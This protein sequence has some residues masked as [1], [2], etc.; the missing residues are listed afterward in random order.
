MLNPLV[1]ICYGYTATS[2]YKKSI[3]TAFTDIKRKVKDGAELVAGVRPALETAGFIAAK[4][5]LKLMLAG[6]AQKRIDDLIKILGDLEVGVREKGLV[7]GDGG[8]GE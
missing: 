3:Y 5:E 2:V 8:D 7:G 6:V 1:P 4:G